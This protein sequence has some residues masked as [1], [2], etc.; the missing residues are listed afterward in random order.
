VKDSAD[1]LPLTADNPWGN[2]S[3]TEQVDEVRGDYEAEETEEV[4]EIE[5][6]SGGVM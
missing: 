3:D 2:L 4:E 1:T 5:P 6:T